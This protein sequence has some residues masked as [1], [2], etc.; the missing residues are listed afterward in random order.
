LQKKQQKAAENLPLSL[1]LSDKAPSL[2]VVILLTIFA[3]F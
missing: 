3:A 1:F 2:L